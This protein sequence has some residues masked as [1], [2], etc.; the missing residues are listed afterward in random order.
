MKESYDYKYKEGDRIKIPEKY[1]NITDKAN[2]QDFFSGILID[3]VARKR[4]DH[5]NCN[6]IRC[7]HNSRFGLRNAQ[8]FGD[9]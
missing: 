4:S 7:K 3:Q 9:V 8:M 5:Q 2:Q 1:G 6:G